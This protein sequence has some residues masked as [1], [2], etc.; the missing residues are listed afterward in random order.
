MNEHWKDTTSYQKGEARDPRRWDLKTASELV[1][2]VHR[3]RDY[4]GAWLLSC[5]NLGVERVVLDGASVDECR[6]N[7]IGIVKNMLKAHLGVARPENGQTGKVLTP[8]RKRAY[9]HHGSQDQKRRLQFKRVAG[10][11]I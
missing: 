9:S 10:N 11:T 2:R 1:I 5:Y 4:P 6:R 3:H 7:A 8:M